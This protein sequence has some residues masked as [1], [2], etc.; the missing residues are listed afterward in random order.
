MERTTE[1]SDADRVAAWVVALGVGLIVLMV[2]WLVGNRLAGLIWD[3]PVGPTVAFG[4]AIVVGTAVTVIA[5]V[6][7]ERRQRT[8][9]GG[10]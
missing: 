10:T 3:V 9:L 8:D 4:T 2:T 5:G 1:R 6:R 7:F